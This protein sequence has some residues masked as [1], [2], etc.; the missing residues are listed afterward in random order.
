M[1]T[2]KKEA[3]R[4]AVDGC[5]KP[6]IDGTGIP[7]RD[8]GYT[9]LLDPGKQIWSLAAMWPVSVTMGLDISLTSCLIRG[10]LSRD[11]PSFQHKR[12]FT[13]R[14]AWLQLLN[15]FYSPLRRLGVASSIQLHGVSIPM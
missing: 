11:C 9:Q 4:E 8:N 6:R 13:S 5:R 2:I 3:Q 15:N 7:Q 10:S 1:F 12:S 14:S